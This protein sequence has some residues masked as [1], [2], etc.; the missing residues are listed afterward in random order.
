MKIIGKLSSLMLLAVFVS[1]CSSTPPKPDPAYAPAVPEAMSKPQQTNGSIYQSRFS[2]ALFEDRRAR[3]IGDII[4][5]VLTEST[6]SSKNA[7]TKLAKTN[8]VTLNNPT[9]MGGAAAA[10]SGT[11]AMG[12]DTEHAFDGS[13]SS[14]QSNSLS[15]NIAVTVMEILPNGNMKVR[16]EKLLTLNQGSEYIR[17]SG[18]VRPIDVRSDNSVLST[19]VANARISYGGTG[20]L[21]DANRNGW[22]SQFFMKVWPF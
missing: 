11:L 12:F 21:A 17:L 18:I 1:A 3:R 6:Q 5:I 22:L 20:A 13:G 10:G 15:G 9:I 14:S 7:K 2:I 4:N 8:E 19:Q 16:G